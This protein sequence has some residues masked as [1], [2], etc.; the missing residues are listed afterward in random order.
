MHRKWL[1]FASFLLACGG[2]DAP[3]PS[4]A[5]PPV[6]EQPTAGAETE[7]PPDG[8]LP[9]DV[10]P[11]RYSLTL[12]IDPSRER[13]T[14]VVEIDVELPRRQRVIYLHG[15]GLDVREASVTES[16]RDAREATWA[17]LDDEGLASVTLARPIGPGN[18]RLRISYGAPYDP[19]LSGFYRVEEDGEHYV[20][21]QMEPLSARRAFPCFDEPSF[22]TP[23]DVTMVVRSAD[24][25]IANAREISTTDAGDGIRR[26]RFATTERIPSYLIA[27][28]VG[29]FDVVDGDPIPA[30]DVRS[31]PLP[32]RAIAP[33]GHG[34]QLAH[35]IEHTPAILTW[36]ETYFG[37]AYPFDKLDLIAVPDFGAGAMENP[38]AVTFRDSLLLLGEDPPISQQRGFAY[39]TAHELAHMW[40][41]NLVTMQ[42]W[43]DLWLN[44]AFASW[45][46]SQTIA[47]TFPAFEPSVAA[48]QEA[49]AAMDADSLRSARQIRQPIESSHDIHNAFDAITYLKGQSVL[50]MFERWL[51]P[52]VFQRGVRSYLGAHAEANASSADLLDALSEAAGRDVRG[53]M[54]SFLQQPGVPLV[55]VV[56]SC[57][58]EHGSLSLRQSRYLPLG[59]Q[60][61]RESTW[62]IPFCARYGVDGEVRQ[63]C[64]VLA[65]AE[66]EL[67]LEGCPDWVMPNAGGVGYYRW[68]LPA[69]QLDALRRRGLSELS[70][71]EAMSF[72]DSVK[73]SFAAGRTSYADAMTALRPLARR[74]ERALATAP[75]SLTEFALT[76]LLDEDGQTR[77]RRSATRLYRAAWRRLG[78][79]SRAG[80]S[81]DAQLYRREL[82]SFLALEAEDGAIR[83]QAGDLG[84]AYLGLRGDGEIHADAVAP[85]LASTVVAV[86]VQ[87][88]G[89][90]VFE[91]VLERLLRS[92]D[93]MVRRNLLSGLARGT[94][95]PALRER[96]LGLVI[97][98]ESGL[99]TNEVF[100]PLRGLQHDAAG[101]EL[102]WTWLQ[103]HYD[104]IL[105]RMG[106]HMAGYL[107]Y[108]AVSQCSAERAAEV[109]AFF[110]DRMEATHGGPRN[111]AKAVERIEL[112]AA[113]VEHGRESATAFFAR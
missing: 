28:A 83:R 56:P 58:G 33:R 66:G 51:T 25:A 107:P 53:P 99:R 38:G 98:P 36:L 80:E 68:S 19:N 23:Y 110:A 24:V 73:S 93:P 86:A 72:A 22:K 60:A 71:R 35:A 49:V 81:P 3:A 108:V 42:W 59:S 30:N 45:M 70:V 17:S 29:P 47:A 34:A 32:F 104:A 43:D 52:E 67:A 26:V 48:M 101:R 63:A 111:L 12:A 21:S 8:R 106:P 15:R 77:A 2:G 92:H 65:A 13:F 55:E 88:G 18:V 95:E 103:A 69:D 100:S 37:R 39:V 105:A 75:I 112:C 41:G 10:R 4:Q 109:Q 31:T 54:N 9:R 11:T 5:P 90:R 76:R 27:I 74:E 62:Q 85:D 44:E 113:R 40:F 97:D 87:Q 57:D 96:L 91:H 94:R 14:G 6:Q 89:E 7:P 1:V 61:N 16:G 64:T 102:V 46:E 20:F 84:R 50:A 78:F 82:L 79:S